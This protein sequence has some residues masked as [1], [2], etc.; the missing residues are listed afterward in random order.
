MP[1]DLL[2]AVVD[3]DASAREA[4]VDLVRAMGFTAAGFA[5][6]AAFLASDQ[7]GRTRCLIA[8]LRMAGM[9][10]IELCRH[11][12]ASGHPVPA[13]LVTAYP[14][15]ESRSQAKA[16]GIRSYLAKPCNP[17]ALLRAMR[18]ALAS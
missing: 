18:G 9:G 6:A 4:L 5:S 13:I 2:I 12:A 3:D 14:D 1:A 11:M 17:D 16:I 10:G 15:D 7:F 8:D